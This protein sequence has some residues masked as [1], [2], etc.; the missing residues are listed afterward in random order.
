MATLVD[1]YDIGA[2]DL[3]GTILQ[4]PDRFVEDPAVELIRV[5]GSGRFVNSY[6]AV[7]KGSPT[8]RFVS[9]EIRTIMRTGVGS[10]GLELEGLDITTP[11]IIYYTKRDPT[12]IA[13]SGHLTTT[14]NE[15]I[16]FPTVLAFDSRVWLLSVDIYAFSADGSILPFVFGTAA[17]PTFAVPAE[18]YT[19]GKI[20]INA[21]EIDCW[22][23]TTLNTNARARHIHH[24]GLHFPIRAEVIDRDPRLELTNLD[25]TARSTLA[26]YWTRTT[27][28]ELFLR[29]NETDDGK[30]PARVA[31]ADLE[32]IRFDG[33]DGLHGPLE[34]RASGEEGAEQDIAIAF[35]EN[36]AAADIIP[37]YDVAI[38]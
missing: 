22:Q 6:S 5:K 3:G 10:A 30:S 2:I 28:V 29:K 11:V 27:D 23:R 37:N 24:K 38:T 34:T 16:M 15:G 26:Q 4:A 33:I 20:T 12:A 35:D 9:P 32:H 8:F 14:I 36:A 19:G 1:R 21:S 31:D 7:E 25:V 17:L 13:S 18:T